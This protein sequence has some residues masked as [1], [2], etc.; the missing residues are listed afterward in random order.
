ML[1]GW[2]GVVRRSTRPVAEGANR[3]KRAASREGDLLAA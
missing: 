2:S 3:E 1:L